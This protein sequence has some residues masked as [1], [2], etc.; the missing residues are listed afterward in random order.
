M[1]CPDVVAEVTMAERL[2]VMG[3]MLQLLL[4]HT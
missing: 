2:T 1:P 3:I 4:V